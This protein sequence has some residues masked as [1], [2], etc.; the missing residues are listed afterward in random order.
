MALINV[1][2]FKYLE[3]FLQAVYLGSQCVND[4][5]PVFQHEVLQLLGGLHL[6]DVLQRANTLYCW[7]TFQITQIITCFSLAE[8][9]GRNTITI[10]VHKIRQPNTSKQCLSNDI[11]MEP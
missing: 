4:V 7:G 6:L 9:N 10:H 1:F 2:I 11:N 5:L 8:Q 3:L